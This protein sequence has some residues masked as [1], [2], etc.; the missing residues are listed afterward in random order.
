MS[1]QPLQLPNLDEKFQTKSMDL[2]KPHFTPTYTP[3]TYYERKISYGS[4]GFPVE[5]KSRE[6]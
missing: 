6:S 1:M 3:N 5:V 2:Q 4:Q